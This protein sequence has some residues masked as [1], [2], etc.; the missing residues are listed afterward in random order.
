M[1]NKT[2][3]SISTWL[4]LIELHFWLTCQNMPSFFVKRLYTFFSLGISATEF[5]FRGLRD[6]LVLQPLLNFKFSL[7]LKDFLFRLFRNNRGGKS[8]LSLYTYIQ[9]T[10]AQCTTTS[11]EILYSLLFG[12]YSFHFYLVC[13]FK[14]IF[15]R[16]I[17]WTVLKPSFKVL[18]LL[19]WYLL[20]H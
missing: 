16:P 6:F 11:W 15:S 8:T 17:F 14:L 18:L 3:H 1:N 12:F 20:L 7:V 5:L 13:Y 4:Y 10:K 19:F 9:I 2:G